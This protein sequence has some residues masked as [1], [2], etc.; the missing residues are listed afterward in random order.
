MKCVI[1][2]A[3]IVS[4]KAATRADEM[5]MT[6]LTIHAQEGTRPGRTATG[7]LGQNSIYKGK[8]CTPSTRPRR[9]AHRAHQRRRLCHDIGHIYTPSS[10][11]TRSSTCTANR[12]RAFSYGSPGIRTASS[13]V[14]RALTGPHTYISQ[15]SNVQGEKVDLHDSRGQPH[16]C[17]LS[18]CRNITCLDMSYSGG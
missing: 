16:H 10:I 4:L 3:G 5:A 15:V 8:I 7:M 17:R 1:Q 11:L 14:P 2:I 12:L 6:A 18:R 13:R 9:T